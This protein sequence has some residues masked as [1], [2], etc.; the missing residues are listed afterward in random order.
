[1]LLRKTVVPF[2]VLGG[3][4]VLLSFPPNIEKPFFLQISPKKTV[5][6]G[7]VSFFTEKKKRC[8]VGAQAF[9]NEQLYRIFL[10]MRCNY[11][12]FFS[13]ALGLYHI[14]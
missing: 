14:F 8:F 13:N 7:C 12:A 9:F 6:R 2:T 11:I 1:M 10:V 5:I 3:K 4:R